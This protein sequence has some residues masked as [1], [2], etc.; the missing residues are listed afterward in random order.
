MEIDLKPLR[1]ELTPINNSFKPIKIDK[2][3]LILD[4]TLDPL[5]VEIEPINITGLKG[6]NKRT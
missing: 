1:V 4:I 2:Q 3:D 5:T 6:D